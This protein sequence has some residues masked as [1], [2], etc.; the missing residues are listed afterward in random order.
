MA[1]RKTNEMTEDFA[2]KVPLTPVAVSAEISRQ[3]Q[4][5]I[6]E[7]PEEDEEESSPLSRV[8]ATLSDGDEKARVKVYKQDPR[9][10][11]FAYCGDYTPDQ[12]EMGG[13]N[14]IREDWGAGTFELRLYGTNANGRY[15]VMA[16]PTIIIAE[17]QNNGSAAVSSPHASEV[18]QA[19][20]ILAEGQKA[21]LQALTTQ[22]QKDPMEEMTRM[23]TLMTSM[24]EAMGLNNAPQQKST[25]GE[26]VDAIKELRGA[27]ELISPSKDDAPTTLLGMAPAFLDTIKTALAARNGQSAMPETAFPALSVPSSIA[28]AA[29]PQFEQSNDATQTLPQNLQPEL[30][31]D[32]DM[33]EF[34]A[35]ASRLKKDFIPHAGNMEKVQDMAE[36]LEAKAPEQFFEVLENPQWHELL[37]QYAPQF[38]P[39]LVPVVATHKEWL[40]AV[41]DALLKLLKDGD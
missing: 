38:F 18:S 11:T 17:K 20:A 24:R 14:M 22:P 27:S 2:A 23:L 12:F 6:P 9:M 28:G 40:S 32:P 7:T 37:T 29:T 26:L 15:V 31:D 8:L 35:F 1:T 34:L 19:I 3:L 39:A 13:E 16:K 36:L 30:E 10:K 4:N 41:R 33:L 21:I 5:L 25:V